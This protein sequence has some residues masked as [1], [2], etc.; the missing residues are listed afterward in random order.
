[1]GFIDHLNWYYVLVSF[2]C[3]AFFVALQECNK[4]VLVSFRCYTFSNV[5]DVPGFVLVSF[6]CYSVKGVPGNYTA[7][8]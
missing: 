8:F 2:R 4:S 6:R 7:L 1:M 3:Y 5:I